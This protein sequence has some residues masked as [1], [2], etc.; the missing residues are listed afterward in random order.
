MKTI[1]IWALCLAVVLAGIEIGARFILPS[2]EAHPLYLA[3]SRDF[4]HLQQL[5]EDRQKHARELKYYDYHLYARKPSKTPS[6][7]FTEYWSSRRTPA[8][9]PRGE[10]STIVWTFGGSTMQNLETT[11]ELSIANTIA[12]SF[13]AYGLR[14]RVENFGTQSFH[15]PLE[16][17]RFTHLLAQVPETE[18]PAIAIFYDGFNDARHGYLF[19]A[20]RIQYDLGAKIAALVEGQHTK[21]VLYSASSWLAKLSFAWARVHRGL[22]KHIW[23][24][25]A[26]AHPTDENLD[27]TVKVYVR[28]V[29]MIDAV[30]RSFE[31]RCFFFLQPLV[32]TKTPLAPIERKAYAKIGES[33]VRFVRNFYNSVSR[34][35]ANKENFIDLSGVLNNRQ[36]D[37]FYDFGHTSALTSPVIGQAIAEHIRKRLPQ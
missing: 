5:L 17:I 7:T 36:T 13:D 2:D 35:L 6:V 29:T 34:E 12:K 37:D 11:D 23:E 20:G 31:I 27:R 21:L 30:C 9:L 19:G 33:R 14:P 4:K 18:R 16:L 15:T 3:I 32:V 22:Q 26:S 25:P 28:N 24:R 1:G 8:S 10:S